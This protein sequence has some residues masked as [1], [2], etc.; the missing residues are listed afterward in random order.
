MFHRGYNIEDASQAALLL[1]KSHQGIRLLLVCHGETDWSHQKRFQGQID[2]PLN[3]MGR[4]QAQQAA[5]FFKQISIK[6]TRSSSALKNIQLATIQR[7]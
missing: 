7:V 2:V 4:Q 3:Q 5:E 1:Q 6:F